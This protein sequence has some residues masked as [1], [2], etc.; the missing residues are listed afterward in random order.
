M[1]YLNQAKLLLDTLPD[2]DDNAEDFLCNA[3]AA[4]AFALVAIAKRMG[5]QDAQNEHIIEMDKRMSRIQD[6]QSLFIERLEKA[7]DRD[8][9][10]SKPIDYLDKKLFAIDADLRELIDKRQ[11]ILIERLSG[12]EDRLDFIDRDEKQVESRV[13]DLER[14]QLDVTNMVDI[15][16]DGVIVERIRGE[17]SERVEGR[18]AEDESRFQATIDPETGIDER[19]STGEW[20]QCPAC[21]GD[22]IEDMEPLQPTPL[23]RCDVCGGGGRIRVPESEQREAQPALWEKLEEAEAT[24]LQQDKKL[25]YIVALLKIDDPITWDDLKAKILNTIA[26]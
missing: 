21:S 25:R 14:R 20:Q 7:E 13:A 16:K 23:Q 5:E 3:T 12:T 24:I 26:G 2:H 19:M 10:E 1:N 18:E 17:R 9:L 22:S 8:E 15:V 11:R 6:V 4:Q